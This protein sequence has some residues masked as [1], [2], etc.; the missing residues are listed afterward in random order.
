MAVFSRI[1]E[2]SA[3]I[4][5]ARNFSNILIITCGGCINESLAYSNK[6]P[7]FK[8]VN[9]KTIAYAVHLEAKRISKLL[10]D[11]KHI[12]KVFTSDEVKNLGWEDGFLC[13]RKKG[14]K[15]DLFSHIGNFKPDLILSICCA[16]G[17]FG[18]V[19]N[20]ETKIP[21]KQITK[22]LGMLTYVFDY[23]NGEQ[24][25]DYSHTKIIGFSK[26]MTE[27]KF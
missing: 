2:D 5:A 7:I 15:F 23:E 24:T 25:I 10:S 11:N 8:E 4:D 27:Q 22:P 17:T 9:G 19:D 26:E 6:L 1:L 12:V 16:A 13:I 3:I 21:V 14:T 18:I 20:Y